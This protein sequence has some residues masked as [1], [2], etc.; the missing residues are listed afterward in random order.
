MRNLHK[1]KWNSYQ[2]IEETFNHISGEEYIVKMRCHLT[3]ISLSKTTKL[4]NIICW[5]G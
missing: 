2:I 1:R 4:E 3:N 5:W